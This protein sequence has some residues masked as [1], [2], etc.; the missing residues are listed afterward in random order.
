MYRGLINL[1]TGFVPHPD[2]VARL[3]EGWLLSGDA[4]SDELGVLLCL[5]AGRALMSHSV[6]GSELTS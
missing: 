6:A 1:Y 4:M 2:V 5:A 3:G